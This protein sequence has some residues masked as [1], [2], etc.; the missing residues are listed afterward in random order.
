MCLI[1]RVDN[2]T[3]GTH[4]MQGTVI[5]IEPTRTILRDA[6]N[7]CIVHLANSEVGGHCG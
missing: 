1:A 4:H 7:R 6:N 2:R 5:N 3:P